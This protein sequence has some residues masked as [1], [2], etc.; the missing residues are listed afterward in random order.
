MEPADPT[1]TISGDLPFRLAGT[2]KQNSGYSNLK[3][4]DK[5]F[6]EQD[7]N[8]TPE[9]AFQPKISAKPSE[10]ASQAEE[11]TMQ[12][13]VDNLKRRKYK[14]PKTKRGRGRPTG[15]EKWNCDGPLTVDEFR[16]DRYLYEPS[17][18]FMLRIEEALIRFDRF[19][20]MEPERRNI[21]HK[22]LSYGGIA[23][24]HNYG[25]GLS[26][27]D[28]K[29][30]TEEEAMRARTQ[31]GIH[32]ERE[33]M[34]INFNKVARG[35][36]GS[37]FGQFFS[38]SKQSEIDL[39]TVTIH[40]FL[41]YLLFHD[42]CPEYKEDILQARETC[43]LASKE[44]WKNLKLLS[45]SP[46]AFNKACSFLFGGY[47]FD[48]RNDSSDWSLLKYGITFGAAYEVYERFK[49]ALE[50]DDPNLTVIPI[51]DIDGFEIVSIEEAAPHVLVNY[52]K[53]AAGHT[54]VGIVHAKSFRDPSKAEIDLSPQEQWDWDHGKAPSY[55]F[56]FLLETD[57]L[58]FCSPGLKII[59]KVMELSCGLHFFDQM[60]AIYPT[61]YEC[62]HNDMML[63]WKTPKK[64]AQPLQPSREASVFNEIVSGS[65]E[66]PSQPKS[67][68]GGQKKVDTKHY[69]DSDTDFDY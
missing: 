62:L 28:M 45:R 14:G 32:K 13:I 51:R 60:I 15:F 38:P 37:F 42:V 9:A 24:G 61:F 12:Q 5:A 56:T 10:P 46:G 30:L 64:I 57:L 48:I 55:S 2:T 66:T 20:R 29:T 52:E 59:T 39:G 63:H 49:G 19:R 18:P 43:N 44:L 25:G 53:H 58:Q 1:K 33:G 8:D 34:E 67:E 54:P 27:Q 3:G 68:Q 16:E 31:L 40:N 47:H 65:P 7:N 50:E 41:T 11:H 6:K 4:D 23:T 17:R 69:E 35:F 21:F 22:Y 36:L 26:N